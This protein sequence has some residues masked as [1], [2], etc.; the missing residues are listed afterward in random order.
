ME[1]MLQLSLRSCS[2]TTSGQGPID[3]GRSRN[4]FTGSV[5]QYTRVLIIPAKT[6]GV[7]C[8]KQQHEVRTVKDQYASYVASEVW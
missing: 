5:Q 4:R 7:S 2:A 8:A 3:P 1:L 6:T